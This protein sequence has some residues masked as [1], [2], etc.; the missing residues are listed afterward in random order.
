MSCLYLQEQ[1]S[2]WDAEKSHPARDGPKHHDEDEKEELPK[3]CFFC[4][5]F[6]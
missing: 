3:V 2:R 4:L 6:Q 1:L 5:T